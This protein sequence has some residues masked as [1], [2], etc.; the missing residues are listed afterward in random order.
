MSTQTKPSRKERK[1]RNEKDGKLIKDASKGLKHSK[2]DH[3]KKRKD[4]KKEH[5]QRKEASGKDPLKE[6]VF[7]LGGDTQDYQLVK[8]VSEEDE[9]G[10]EVAEEDVSI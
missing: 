1:S 8:D 6:A 7:A 9:S 3:K 4:N 10:N 2:S 5:I